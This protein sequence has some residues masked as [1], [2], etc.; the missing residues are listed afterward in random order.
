[1]FTHIGTIFLSFFNSLYKPFSSKTRIVDTV[2][3]YSEHLP[4]LYSL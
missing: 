4:E 1:M 3:N 2:S